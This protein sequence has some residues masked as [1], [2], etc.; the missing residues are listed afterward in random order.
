MDRREFL[1]SAAGAGTPMAATAAHP[2]GLRLPSRIVPLAASVSAAARTYLAA[3]IGPDG[4][5]HVRP[6][7]PA[8]NDLAAWATAKVRANEQM[9][10]SFAAEAARLQSSCETVRMA[11]VVVQVATPKGGPQHEERAFLDV[12]GGALIYGEGEFC[13]LGARRASDNL[14]VRAY[15]VDY[16]TPPEHPYPAG[17]DDCLAVYRELLKRYQP[18]NII[19]GGLSAGGNLAAALV[20]R[21]RD[22]GLPPPAAVVLLTPEV[23][24]TESG[25]SFKTLEGLDISY[26]CTLMPINLLYAAGHDLAHPYLSPLFGDFSKGYPPTFLQAGTRD[27]FLSN[28]VRLH[29]ALRRAGVSA[30]L[31][32]FEAM[33]HGGFHGAPEDRELDAEVRRFVDEHWGR[34]A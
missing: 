33:P 32:I 21:A 1:A 26:P 19:V 23:D 3:L 25:D 10:A 11:G 34:K 6:P 17:L 22:E 13:K 24:L 29:R 27:V 4:G 28:T 5:P 18:Q 14:G 15:G 20:L 16:R 2:E 31:H 9:D 8:P 7:F 12:H 30:E